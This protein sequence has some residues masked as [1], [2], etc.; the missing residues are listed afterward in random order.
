MYISV[1]KE[2]ILF[3]VQTEKRKQ[4]I[5]EYLCLRIIDENVTDA[6]VS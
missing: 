3:T 1:G 2:D 4:G 5:E 6:Q